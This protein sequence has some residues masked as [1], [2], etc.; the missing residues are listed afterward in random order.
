MPKLLTFQDRQHFLQVKSPSAER[1][2]LLLMT[3]K[4]GKKFNLNDEMKASIVETLLAYLKST[5][6]GKMSPEAKDHH[7]IELEH[8]LFTALK[9]F[10]SNF[11]EGCVNILQQGLIANS[12]FTSDQLQYCFKIFQVAFSSIDK[13]SNGVVKSY[14]KF[15]DEF[16][17]KALLLSAE[18]LIQVIETNNSVLKDSKIQ[19]DNTKIDEILCLLIDPRIN[20]STF[21]IEDFFRF[22]SAVGETLFVIANVRQ[23][24]F[25]LRVSQFFNIYRSFIENVYFY[26]NES[27]DELT[28]SE[29]SL[30]LKLALQL[31]K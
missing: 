15:L 2:K 8:Q 1:V 26:K 9:P 27:P 16:S 21:K 7:S 12:D 31:E 29:I 10:K 20:P 28:Q 22:Y 11:Q 30:L 24:Y 17:Q 23:N 5:M 13:S 4:D 6:T 14:V 25:K 19:L 3:L 18:T